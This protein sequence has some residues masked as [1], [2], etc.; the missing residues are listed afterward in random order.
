MTH[1]IERASVE[2]VRELLAAELPS[3]A[4]QEIRAGK[5]GFWSVDAK[6]ALNA[7]QQA[8]DAGFAEGQA[9]FLRH[10]REVNADRLAAWEGDDQKTDGIFHAT[11]LGGEV[12]EVLNV[13]KKLH[14]EAMGWRGSRATIADLSDEI[15]D[16]LICLDKLAAHY[17]ID[18]ATATAAKFNAT[19]D[20]VGLPHKLSAEAN[21]GRCDAEVKS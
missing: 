12:G 13:V 6:S 14:R 4:A 2:Q 19:S 3:Q 21:E 5:E 1:P 15:G 7:I 9:D 16:V 8:R 17:G 11:E 10:L 20:K 18:L